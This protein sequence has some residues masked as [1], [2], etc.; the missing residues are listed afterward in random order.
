MYCVHPRPTGEPLDN[1]ERVLAAIA[2]LVPHISTALAAF[3]S[4]R[5]YADTAPSDLC[6]MRNSRH[7]EIREAAERKMVELGIAMSI[8]KPAVQTVQGQEWVL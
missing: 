8:V 7:Q 4:M 1:A 6:G 5:F 3:E 2:S